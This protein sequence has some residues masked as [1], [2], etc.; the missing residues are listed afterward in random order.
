M[1]S[2]LLRTITTRDPLLRDRSLEEICRDASL[3]ELLGETRIL[4]DFSQQSENLYERVRALMFLYAI[5]RFYLPGKLPEPGKGLVP[6]RS[7]KPTTMMAC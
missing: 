5:H 7:R 2:E 4:H 1:T 3:R 6:C